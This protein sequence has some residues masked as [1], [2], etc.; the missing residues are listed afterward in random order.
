M[1]ERK[2]S[3]PKVNRIRASPSREQIDELLDL[4]DGTKVDTTKHERNG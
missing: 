1:T 4:I 3:V 2:A